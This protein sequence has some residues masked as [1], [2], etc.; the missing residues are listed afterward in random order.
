MELEN[1]CRIMQLNEE[2]PQLLKKNWNDFISAWDGT[3]PEFVSIDF[4]KKYLPFLKTSHETEILERA[5]KVIDFCRTSKEAALYM[6]ILYHGAFKLKLQLDPFM[7]SKVFGENEGIAYL[8][9]ALSSAPDIA[10]NCKKRGIPERYAED[11]LQWIGGTVDIYKLAHNGI[12][13]HT[14]GQ[15]YWLHHHI[16]G[17]LYRIGRFEYL[18]HPLPEWAPL[19]FRNDAGVLAV[20]AAPGVKL[21][22]D[23][24]VVLKDEDAVSF[25]EEDGSFITGMPCSPD[26]FVRINERLT[27]DRREFKPV[28]APWDLVPSIHIPGGLRMKWEDVLDSMKQ[29]KEF[30]KRYCKREIPMIVCGSWILNPALE[31]FAP[32]GNMARFRKEVCCVPMIRWGNEGRDGM[33]FAFGRGDVDPTELDAVN[34][35]QKVIQ[36][37]FAAEGTL[38]TGGMFVLTEDLDKLGNQYYRTTQKFLG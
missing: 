12:A 6:F 22:K 23:G 26:G 2:A 1:F 3:L 11:A 30:F 34:S 36:Q 20:L 37:I 33:F 35:I 4:I 25:I 19:I 5:Q 16:D 32:N 17:E 18:M 14:L 7:Q 28:C 10:G 27:V 29:A 38:R 21:N 13:G 15:L 8:I 31:K 9:A 24:L